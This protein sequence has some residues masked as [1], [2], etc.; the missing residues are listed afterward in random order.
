MLEPLAPSPQ[1]IRMLSS[2]WGYESN[3]VGVPVGTVPQ[4]V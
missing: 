1:Q 4:G 2:F 3:I